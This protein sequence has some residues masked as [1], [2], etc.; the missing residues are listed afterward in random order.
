[1]KFIDRIRLNDAG[2][3]WSLR[4]CRQIADRDEMAVT[5]VEDVDRV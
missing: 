3:G 5:A 2:E 4:C 1:V